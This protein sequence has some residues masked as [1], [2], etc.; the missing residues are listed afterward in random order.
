MPRKTVG[1]LSRLLLSACLGFALAGCVTIGRFE[2]FQNDVQSRDQ[3]T[4][5]N[6][7]ELRNEA[8]KTQKIQAEIRADIIDLRT[9]FQELTGQVSTRQYGSEKAT[10]ERQAMESS[11]AMQL[12]RIQTQHQAQE[13][14]LARLEKY[15]G[16]K[17]LPAP[18]SKLTGEGQ[19]EATTLQPG[20]E[21]QGGLEQPSQLSDGTQATP[22]P[23][24]VTAKPE[25]AY[26]VAYRLFK[27]RKFEKARTAFEQFVLDYPKSGLVGNALFWIGETYYQ[28]G[29][30]ENAIFKYQEVLE[31]YPKGSKA[32]DALLKTG[33]ALEKMGEKKAALAAF[34]KVQKKY[35]NSSQ[36]D[37]ARKKIQELSVNSKKDTGDESESKAQS[38]ATRKKS[39]EKDTRKNPP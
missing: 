31:K 16:L 34:Q 39:T 37:L 10:R 5:A 19:E 6:L 36:V 17:P 26:E 14:R 20:A 4:Q 24:M 30:F 1:D 23:A 35:P 27:S 12:S 28:T 8:R 22:P 18:T 3:T 29:K 13:A 9:E 38:P 2:Q 33:L 25:E 32:P 11:M 15:L 21:E 7:E